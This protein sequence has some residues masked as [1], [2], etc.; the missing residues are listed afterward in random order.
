MVDNVFYKA[1]DNVSLHFA[2]NSDLT[3]DER[4]LVTLSSVFSSLAG[5]NVNSIETGRDN[6]DIREALRRS[7]YINDRPGFEQTAVRLAVGEKRDLY[8]ARLNTIKD[9]YGF[10][11]R[12]NIVMRFICKFSFR[13][14]AD[15]YQ[16]RTKKDFKKISKELEFDRL[17]KPGTKKNEK[18][19]QMLIDAGKWT[20]D[21]EKI[22]DYRSINSLLGWDAVCLVNLVRSATQVHYIERSDFIKYALPIKKQVQNAYRD[23]QEV[24]LAYVIGSFMWEYSE[25]KSKAIIRAAKQFLE[26]PRSLVHHVPFK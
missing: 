21:L 8:M 12:S 16:T 15:W 7:W 11:D 13:F 6:K 17:A 20:K 24:V 25:P 18:I 3:D 4:W 19:Y 26:D 5:D 2:Q 22:G 14:A 10:I 1:V 23:W 9:F